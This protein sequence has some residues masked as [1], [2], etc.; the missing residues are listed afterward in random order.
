MATAIVAVTAVLYLVVVPQA[1]ASIVS[2]PRLYAVAAAAAPDNSFWIATNYGAVLSYGPTPSLGGMS[3]TNLNGNL[4]VGMASTT[5]D[6]GY[7]LVGSDGGVFAFGDAQ[8][9]GR[10]YFLPAVG[11]AT[12]GQG[13]SAGYVIATSDGQTFTFLPGKVPVGTPAIMPLNAPI[14]GIVVDNGSKYGFWLIGS[15]GGVF[16]IGGAP[17]YGSEG[18]TTQP[19]PFVA[20]VAPQ[21][22]QC[23][24]EF[25]NTTFIPDTS[26]DDTGQEVAPGV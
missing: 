9:L 5:D 22:G 15:D 25:D 26:C 21:Y 3:G 16:S 8:W 17:F 23:Y 19:N 18:G 6:N 7:W 24:S 2:Q 4:I 13:T 14:V 10:E 20:I 12:Y 11:I 1:G